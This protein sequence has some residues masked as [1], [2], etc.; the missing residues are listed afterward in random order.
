MI[1]KIVNPMKGSGGRARKNIDAKR[2]IPPRKIMPH[3][4]RN[5]RVCFSTLGISRYRYSPE[6]QPDPGKEA[7]IAIEHNV[8]GDTSRD[9]ERIA[10][11]KHADDPRKNR[12]STQES[13]RYL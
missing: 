9:I 11:A 10:E 3:N 8:C 13:H 12:D 7:K 6:A 2:P 5:K 4:T 1:S